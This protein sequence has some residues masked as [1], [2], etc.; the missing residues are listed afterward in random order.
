MLCQASMLLA[1][2]PI[3]VA[4]AQPFS[5]DLPVAPSVDAT[6]KE[7]WTKVIPNINPPKT[8]LFYTTSSSQSFLHPF[9]TH[10]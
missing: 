4:R 6:F 8:P 10:Y 9:Q 7:A 3:L 5:T 2:R 1:R